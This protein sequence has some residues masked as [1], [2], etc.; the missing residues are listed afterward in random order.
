MTLESLT[1]M[2]F[3]FRLNL[4]TKYLMP[5]PRLSI[6]GSAH[7][8]D[9]WGGSG[10][11]PHEDKFGAISHLS[12]PGC[13]SDLF[14]DAFASWLGNHERSESLHIDIP[15]LQ[16]LESGWGTGEFGGFRLQNET[17]K[18]RKLSEFRFKCHR[19]EKSPC[20]DDHIIMDFLR[21]MAQRINPIR[22]EVLDTDWSVREFPEDHQLAGHVQETTEWVREMFQPLVLAADKPGARLSCKFECLPDEA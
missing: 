6:I 5:P 10:V 22:L 18:F 19:R 13:F 20:W 3:D 4:I 16:D 21:W 15:N 2:S 9:Y 12:L 7:F 17:W 14:R 1:L 8:Y 11:Y